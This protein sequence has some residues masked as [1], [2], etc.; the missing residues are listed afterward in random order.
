MT[1][2]VFLPDSENNGFFPLQLDP[3]TGYF[4]FIN[5]TEKM[6]MILHSR[7]CNKDTH[8]FMEIMDVAFYVK[9]KVLH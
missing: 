4:D 6:P 3:T 5:S 9:E 1:I 2:T 7:E 8:A